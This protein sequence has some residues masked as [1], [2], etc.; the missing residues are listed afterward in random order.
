[1]AFRIEPTNRP[2]DQVP[3][4]IVTN[5]GTEH[6]VTLPK[7]D[8]LPPA[9]VRRLNELLASVEETDTLVE[10]NRASLV[11]IDPDHEDVWNQLAERQITQVFKHWNEESNADEGASELGESEA[12]SV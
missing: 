7:A 11:A 2:E 6:D 10:V 9:T 4:T 1:M 12:S 5:D 3:F 8:C